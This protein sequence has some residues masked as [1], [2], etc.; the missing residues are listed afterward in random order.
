MD[1]D[2]KETV[3]PEISGSQLFIRTTNNGNQAWF[4]YSTNNKTYQRF[5]PEFTLQF[6]KWTGD[7][8]GFFCW[9][10]KEE[11]GWMDVD[12]FQY[13]YDGPK[14]STTRK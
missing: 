6:G 1:K 11:K 9:N 3:G 8:L 4:E 10:D 13:E 12:W 2:G 7:R 5:G 14:G